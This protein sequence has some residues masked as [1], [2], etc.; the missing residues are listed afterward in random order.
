MVVIV[1]VPVAFAVV[2]FS[3]RFIFMS[4]HSRIFVMSDALG[5]GASL[6]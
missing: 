5:P 2:P 1:I 3:Y 6:I 4:F